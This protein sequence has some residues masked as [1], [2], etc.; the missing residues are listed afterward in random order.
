MSINKTEFRYS[1]PR[2]MIKR[3][4]YALPA[5]RMTKSGACTR[6]VARWTLERKLTE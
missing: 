1:T 3:K 4:T 6:S 5:S 2:E